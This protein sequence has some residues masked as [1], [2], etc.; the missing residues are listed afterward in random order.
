MFGKYE[1]RIIC[2]AGRKFVPHQQLIWKSA[3]G[4]NGLRCPSLACNEW[5]TRYRHPSSRVTNLEKLPLPP[6]KTTHH[7]VFMT[8]RMEL[9]CVW[10]PIASYDS[11]IY[12]HG[13]TL[14]GR[15]GPLL[16]RPA[17]TLIDQWEAKL[18]DRCQAK[19]AFSPT[20]FE[21]K[22]FCSKALN[23]RILICIPHPSFSWIPIQP[24]FKLFSSLLQ[25]VFFTVNNWITWHVALIQ[26]LQVLVFK[27]RIVY[28]SVI[29]FS[30]LLGQ[31]DVD[32]C[33]CLG[34]P[35]TKDREKWNSLD[36]DRSCLMHSQ[37]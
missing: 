21:H 8:A 10:P 17:S 24:G 9:S 20:F 34:S 13:H 22:P 33:G 16:T 18:L 3:V 11:F 23:K 31:L 36:D 5:H 27:K 29:F 35:T 12:L 32:P 15:S 26:Y 7:W 14:S 25:T 28:N 6:T 37:A 2:S 1:L 4:A 30:I 19:S